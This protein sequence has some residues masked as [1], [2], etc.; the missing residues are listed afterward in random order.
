MSSKK[1]YDYYGIDIIPMDLIKAYYMKETELT[2]GQNKVIDVNKY[3]KGKDKVN[4]LQKTNMIKWVL[5]Y[6]D[7][8]DNNE[9]YIITKLNIAS[10]KYGL[11]LINPLKIKIPKNAKAQ[12]WIN[13]VNKY[14]SKEKREYDFALFLLGENSNEI[15]PKIKVHSLCTNGYISQVIKEDTLWKGDK[16]KTIMG[17]CSKII[18]K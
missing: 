1:K 11:K 12:K 8:S 9:G 13:E 6:E 7:Y 10:V 2:A 3:S 4:L 18:L 5:F 17:I 15:Y 16:E 14:F